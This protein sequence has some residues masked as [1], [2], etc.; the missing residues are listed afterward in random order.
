MLLII[1]SRLNYW[2]GSR[3]QEHIYMYSPILPTVILT[4]EKKQVKGKTKEHG[5]TVHFALC[6][7][8]SIVYWMHKSLLERVSSETSLCQLS[9]DISSLRGLSS[10]H[11]AG[12]TAPATPHS[13]STSL[14]S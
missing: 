8:L 1:A 9:F 7:L 12:L 2:Q 11:T 6:S 13:T 3:D 5:D 4:G 14:K 10:R